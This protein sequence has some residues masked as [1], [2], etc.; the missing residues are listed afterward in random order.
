TPVNLSLQNQT[1]GIGITYQWQVSTTGSTGPWTNVGPNAST[2][3]TTQTQTSSYQVIVSCTEPGG[4]SATSNPVQ[5]TQNSFQDCYCTSSASSTFDE[6]LLNVT[7]GALNNTSI[8]GEVAPGPGSAAGLYSNYKTLTP[9][10]VLPGE[11]VS[12]S[13]G[14][15]T[16]NGNYNSRVAMFIDWN[17]NGL[18][19]DPGEQV[20][21][22][23]VSINGPYTST[24]SITVPVGAVIGTT[25]LRVVNVETS[26][27]IFPCGTYGYGETEDYLISVCAP[28]VAT[29]SVTD[30]C[31]N[32]TFTV[33]VD[34]GTGTY[35]ILY[36]ENGGAQQSAPYAGTPITLGPFATTA[37]VGVTVSAGPGCSTGIGSYASNCPISI[38]CSSTSA[39]VM[40]HC[41]GNNDGRVFTFVSSDPLNTLVFK[42][43]NPS[44]I[45][46][47]DGVTFYDGDVATGTQIP[48]PPAGSDLSSL[49]T[50]TSTGNT[51]SFTIQS[52]GSGSCV[53]A[54]TS[55]DWTFK[56]RCAGCIEPSADPFLSTDCG[57]Y[58]F[59]LSLDVYDLGFSDI[60]GLPTT[61]ATV[62]YTVN[63][64]AQTPITLT[65]PVIVDL[66]TFGYNDVVNVIV[67]HE[68]DGSCDLVLGNFTHN[69]PCAPANDLCVNPISLSVNTP[70]GCPGG[71]ISGTTQDADMTGAL[72]TCASTATVQDV[73]YSFNTGTS[74]SPMTLNLTPGTA[75]NVGYQVFTAC[76]TPY[77]GAGACTAS[78]NGT[79]N[80]AGLAQNTTYLLR[81]FTRTN[82]GV[83]G[84]FNACLSANN[85][86]TLCDAA[87]NIPGVPV[88]NQTLVCGTFNGLNSTTVPTSCGS[89]S[90]TYTAGLES[91]Y[92]FTPS[93]TGSYVVSYTG[94][95][96]S[97]INVWSTA[98]PSAGGTCVGA[99]ADFNASKF[100]IV[101]M[102]A[103]TVYYIWF[104]TWFAASP[105]PGSFSL[106]LETCPTPSAV[107]VTSITHNSASV[108]WTGTAGN[109][110][111]EYGP[112]FAFTP[113]TGLAPGAGGTVI[114][115]S[116]WPYTLTGLSPSTG[117][118]VY[119]RRNCDLDGFSMNSPAVNFTT[120]AT[121]P[122]PP[123]CGAPWYDSGGQSANYGNNE[124]WTFTLCPPVPGD[125]VTIDFTSFS[126][127]AN[128][129]RLHI[130]DGPTTASP[131]FS[132]GNGVGFGSSPYGAGGWWGTTIPG[133]FTTTV[134]NGGCMTFAYYSDG[135]VISTGWESTIICAPPPTCPPPTATSLTALTS[136]TATINWTGAAGTYIIEYGPTASFT[137]PGITNLPGVGGTVVTTSTWPYQITGLSPD[138]EYRVFVRRDCTGE[139]NG[140][141][142]NATPV[143]FNTGGCTNTTAYTTLAAPA[144]GASS[145]I[146]C[147][148][149]G[150][151]GTFSGAVAG[152]QYTVSTTVPTDFISVRSGSFNGPSVA[153][154]TGPLTFTATV[155]G[156]LYVHVNT[157][158]SCGSDFNCR[159][160]TMS[161]PA[162]SCLN[163]TQNGSS[164]APALN[165]TVTNSGVAAGQYTVFTTTA[166]GQTYTVTSSVATDAITVRTGTFDG[167]VLV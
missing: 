101:P 120:S 55:D 131:M 113:G 52:D 132:S 59:D 135:S 8:C 162:I 37:S 19:T 24:G 35:T 160:L 21:I 125:V 118:Q 28:P 87:I 151:Y 142:T 129:D 136:T 111:I 32:G 148:Y 39:L 165:A 64:V 23:P 149:A 110:I 67:A 112:A 98:C 2:Y 10:S 144:S 7:F 123:V 81:V 137:T 40:S 42:F 95:Q 22:S 66:G 156:P 33:S 100:L 89:G 143:V 76:G 51:L 157:N 53:D 56:V 69:S 97:S 13:L 141:S 71:A 1:S 73:W 36:S 14:V 108:N 50:I 104:D 147:I 96:Y 115:T 122:A 155:S 124:N 57:T 25:L 38:D 126:T 29:A 41:Y 161:S 92:T 11:V 15:G 145:T 102:T 152:Q 85:A 77:G 74:L 79:A 94:Q 140:Y 20:Y 80:I 130:Y 83:P 70:S 63:G 166:A 121:P 9:T 84:T 27:D 99:I 78:V 134:A 164:P 91:I 88:T 158:A 72:P 30:D 159:D 163:N 154:G 114:T 49:G 106:S 146:F 31:A 68:D 103:G 116:T 17:Q 75:N 4:G 58:S 47:G 139:L 18:L 16:C 109:Y 86:T 44:P 150:Q 34:A 26:G 61:S 128:W 138:T 60:T 93:V 12:F 153:M 65:E 6:E 46:P 133:P 54:G 62:E 105:C 167:A 119:V 90:S 127:E 82:L 48:L 43:L 45:A 5:V 117:Y 107:T 3:S